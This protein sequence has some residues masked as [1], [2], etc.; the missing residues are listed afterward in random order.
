MGY[1]L[2]TEGYCDG[3]S[4]ALERKHRVP[5][6]VERQSPQPVVPRTG[7]RPTVPARGRRHQPGRHHRGRSVSERHDAAPRRDVRNPA[8]NV[9]RRPRGGPD[10]CVR[11]Q[12]GNTS[13]PAT[14]MAPPP[15][16]TQR[17]AGSCRRSPGTTGSSKASPSAPTAR[18]SPRPAMTR[19]PSCRDLRT[20][21][22]LL[23]LTGHSFALTDV[24]FS[25]DGTRV[26][27]SSG[28]GTVRVYVEL[29]AVARTRL[30]R[31]WSTPECRAF[32]GVS[33]PDIPRP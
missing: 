28:D 16:E 8:H 14:G 17:R 18:C 5:D 32:P 21:K 10:H 22:R 9:R 7:G 6:L 20:G 12:R 23:T 15:F 24:K 3:W 2:L 25:P 1:R 33:C 11:S 26:A 19:P 13:R 29:L 27:T 4:N 31:T 30:T